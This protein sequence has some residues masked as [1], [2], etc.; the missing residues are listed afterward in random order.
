MTPKQ[1]LDQFNL[2]VFHRSAFLRR[3]PCQLFA[4][5]EV[6]AAWWGWQQA[7]MPP[8][9][10]FNADVAKSK[11]DLASGIPPV[12]PPSPD[13]GKPQWIV[14]DLGE[15]GVKIRDRFFFLYKGGNIEYDGEHDEGDR[16]K[17]RM[18]GKRE[19][20]ETCWP[21]KWV[22][23]GRRDDRYTEELVY[24]SG[25]SWGSPEDGKWKELPLRG[26]AKKIDNKK[27]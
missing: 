23:A 1:S 17:Y 21:M 12:V 26:E 2:A 3:P 18:V 6:A 7:L 4:D 16:M 13:D 27:S 15:L 14:N 24:T 5:R 22:M 25:L 10:E 11:D 8:F 9:N 19:F 20:G